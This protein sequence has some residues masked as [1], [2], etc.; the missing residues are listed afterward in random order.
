YRANL[1]KFAHLGYLQVRVI[2]Q[3]QEF[4]F[5][6]KR[7]R[8]NMGNYKDRIPRQIRTW[9]SKNSAPAIIASITNTAA[10]NPPLLLTLSRSYSGRHGLSE[11]VGSLA[12]RNPLPQ[13]FP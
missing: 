9:I 1:S 13:L 5:A 7:F 10:S 12:P 2:L 4:L 11:S 3:I 6:L 8:V